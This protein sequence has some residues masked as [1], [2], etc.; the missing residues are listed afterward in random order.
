MGSPP[1]FLPIA[2]TSGADCENYL[3]TKV[4]DDYLG[5]RLE[6]SLD[7]KYLVNDINNK[8]IVCK[9]LEY[10]TKQNKIMIIQK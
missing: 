10:P 1:E 8:F 3:T 5:F 7:K 2:F 6:N 9:K 4:T